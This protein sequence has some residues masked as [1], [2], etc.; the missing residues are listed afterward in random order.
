MQ[1]TTRSNPKRPTYP[2]SNRR[3]HVA[4]PSPTQ[5]RRSIT[6]RSANDGPVRSRRGQ[7]CPE[8]ADL[9]RGDMIAH[10]RDFHRG[11][12][13][14][15]QFVEFYGARR[16]ST[17]REIFRDDFLGP[18][19]HTCTDQPQ[20]STDEIQSFSPKRGHVTLRMRSYPKKLARFPR[21]IAPQSQ[22]LRP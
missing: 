18:Q 5:N 16:C 17:C 1:R 21:R 20:I 22:N 14:Q 2:S 9:V 4:G 19:N 8:C 15:D 6:R 3:E 11:R 12:E 13:V 10:F 7:R